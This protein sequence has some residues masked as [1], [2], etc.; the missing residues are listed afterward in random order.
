MND[1]R[2]AA[3]ASCPDVISMEAF[4]NN[5]YSSL[6]E[7]LIMA[8]SKKSYTHTPGSHVLFRH[9]IDL[10]ISSSFIRNSSLGKTR[11]SFVRDTNV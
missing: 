7:Q 3:I 4:K 2:I 9:T 5:I 1:E 6:A 10:S 8:S 11:I